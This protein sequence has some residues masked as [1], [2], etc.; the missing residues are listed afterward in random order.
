VIGAVAF[1]SVWP[2]MSTLSG[3]TGLPPAALV[4]EIGSAVRDLAIRVTAAFALLALADYAW[5][6]RRHENQLK[7]TKEQ[8]KQEMR[9]A[10][11]PPE[12]KRNI[13]RRQFEAAR[14]RMLAAVPTADVVVVNPTH[15][16]VA[17][18]YDGSTTAPEVVAKGADLV[19][20]AIRNLA[21]EHEV[22]VVSNPPLA[23]ALYREVEVGQQIPEGLF[24]AVAEVLAFVYRTARRHRRPDLKRRSKTPMTGQNALRQASP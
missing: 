5:Q 21:N 23:R 10:D 12:V 18:R 24:Q 11:L 9:Q 8:V 20:A 1:F 2:R 16:A 7:M 4:H 3:F 17:L 6:R 15:F 22:P 19:A 14:K 13:K